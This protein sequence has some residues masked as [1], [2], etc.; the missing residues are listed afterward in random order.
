MADWQKSYSLTDVKYQS[1]INMYII[2][3]S[4]TRSAFEISIKKSTF[5]MWHFIY[6][7]MYLYVHL[8][9]AIQLIMTDSYTITN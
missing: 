8:I 9:V 3:N 4:V 7:Y 2:V 6:K 1:F 5:L